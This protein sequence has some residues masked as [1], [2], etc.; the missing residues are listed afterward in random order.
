MKI[1]WSKILPNHLTLET[2]R[3]EQFK[4]DNPWVTDR[5]V[6]NLESMRLSVIVSRHPDWID[7]LWKSLVPWTYD[8]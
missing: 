4:R 5:T 2:I 7:G 3:R 6:K 1:D 8:S